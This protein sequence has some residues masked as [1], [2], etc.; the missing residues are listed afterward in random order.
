MSKRIF[1]LPPEEDQT[2]ILLWFQHIYNHFNKM[3]LMNLITVL[4]LL[5][6]LF[7]I[8][9]LINSRDL[10]F[11]VAA[12][13]LAVLA[14]PCITALNGVAV[15]IVHRR[16][17]WLKEDLKRSWKKDWLPSM[18]LTAIL[19]ALWSALIYAVYLVILSQ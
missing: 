10:V 19:G 18:I 16:P 17:V 8:T 1:S 5:P 4:C 3:F 14:G 13:V 12:A 15:R 11:W 2:G 6:A 9:F 7:C